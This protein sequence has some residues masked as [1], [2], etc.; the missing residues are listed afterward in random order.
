MGDPHQQGVVPPHEIVLHHIVEDE[1]RR[2][3]LWWWLRRG[4]SR[5]TEARR[6]PVE[7][8]VLGGECVV[9]TVVLFRRLWKHRLEALLELPQVVDRFMEELHCSTMRVHD[10]LLQLVAVPIVKLVPAAGT[11]NL[12]LPWCRHCG[13]GAPFHG[14][15]PV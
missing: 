15:P 6:V 5:E 10:S 11:D 8:I 7:I 9:S 2:L 3:D 4:H 1:P 13:G 12:D 14:R